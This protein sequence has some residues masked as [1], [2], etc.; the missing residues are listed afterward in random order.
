MPELMFDDDNRPAF[1]AAPRRR[2]ADRDH[3]ARRARA[4]PSTGTRCSWQKWPLRVGFNPREGLVLHQIGYEDRGEPAPGHL[5]GVAVGDG[6]S[7]TATR[8]RRTGTRTSSTRASTGWAAAQPADARLRL[9]RR[10][11]LLRRAR[12]T[13]RTA[14]PVT[15][16]N[17]ICMHEEDYGIA[18]K[19]TDFRTEEVEVRRSR[20][21]VDLAASP[22]SATTSTASSGTSTTTAPSS[23]RSSSPASSPPARWPTAR[24]RGTAIVVAPGLYGPHHQ[25]FFN[26][27]LDMQVDGER[28]SVYE[29][30]AAALP[31][32][33]DNPYGN[34]WVTKKTLLAPGER[35]AAADRPVRRPLLVRRQPERRSTS[36]ASPVG[37]KLMPGDNVLPLQQE[38]S[39]AYDRAQFAYKHLWVTP[40]DAARAVRRGRLPEPARLARRAAGVPVKADRPLENTDVV[41]WYS[42][43]AHH[44]V[45]PE[46]WPVMPVQLRRLHAQ[47]GRLLR[48]QPGARHAPLDAGLPHRQ[49]AR[50]S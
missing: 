37:Y 30:D 42:F 35:G 41:V 27:R 20:R 50:G 38:G 19:H 6:T 43:G 33:P 49:R 46:D 7:P 12:S 32:G 21:L 9:P 31:P 44:V 1:T 18:W 5:P 40:Y 47:A 25:H 14:T 4:S 45:R 39:Q 34:A 11:P 17:A 29:V 28:N 23:T 48:R 10:D 26:V 16:P 8:R 13:T 22:P 15:I 2:Q 24:S 36:S 3:P